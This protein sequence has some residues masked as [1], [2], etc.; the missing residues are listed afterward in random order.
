MCFIRREGN[1]EGDTISNTH[2]LNF[3]THA[4]P[5]LLRSGQAVRRMT[6]ILQQLARHRFKSA[7]ILQFGHISFDGTRLPIY[8]NVGSAQ[9]IEQLLCSRLYVVP[10]WLHPSIF[11]LIVVHRE[12]ASVVRDR[13]NEERKSRFHD[14]NPK[15]QSRL[16]CASTRRASIRTHVLSSMRGSLAARR[17]RDCLLQCGGSGMPKPYGKTKG[18]A[19][20]KYVG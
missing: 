9:C 18:K 19:S 12:Y 6:H 5:C 10:G 15:T 2:G 20:P 1:K 16:T 4:L 14:V 7:N 13:F 17:C 11:V 8:V 3:K